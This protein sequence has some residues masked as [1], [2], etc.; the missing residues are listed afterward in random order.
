MGP[1]ASTKLDQPL[2]GI[3][4]RYPMAKRSSALS[5]RNASWTSGPVRVKATSRGS[6]TSRVW[7][8]FSGTREAGMKVFPMHSVVQFPA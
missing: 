5:A 6:G 4:A 1:V 3:T 7:V 2:S 8:K